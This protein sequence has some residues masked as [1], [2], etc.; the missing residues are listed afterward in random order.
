[1]SVECIHKDA[2]PKM[3]L[4]SVSS[5]LA[6]RWLSE[7]NVH[8]RRLSGQRVRLYAD[9]MRKGLWRNPTGEP[10][11]FD[12]LNRLQDGQH[13]LAAQ[14]DSGATIQYWVNF[15]ADPDD[16]VVIDQG[17]SRNA[18][19]VLST[20]GFS[21]SSHAASIA[22][23]LLLI[24]HRSHRSWSGAV[25][26]SAE[27]SAFAEQSAARL[28]MAVKVARNVWAESRVPT[29]A[30]GAVFFLADSLHPESQQLADF[31]SQVKTGVGLFEGSPAHTLR[32]WAVQRPTNRRDEQ[33]TKVVFVTKAW[34]AF[35]AGR[36]LK[37]LVW[38]NSEMPMP[39]PESPRY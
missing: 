35:V 34:N 25:I 38:L 13:R 33:Q 30:F 28:D 17:K 27:V 22:K 10:I 39:L 7:N 14:V 19:D 23:T 5:E 2:P 29:S 9:V 31:V 36:E 20:Q 37:K 3:Q 26:S 1:M 24:E 6:A 12:R 15:G 16:F 11:I 8:N 21:S 4:V 18:A 32:R